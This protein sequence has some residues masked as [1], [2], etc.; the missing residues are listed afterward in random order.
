MRA[1]RCVVGSATGADAHWE[2][3]KSRPFEPA[4]LGKAAAVSSELRIAHALEYIAAQMGEINVKLS[5][6]LAQR[7]G[8]T[9]F[10]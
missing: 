7:S 10:G 8:G 5:G 6:L 1:A 2:H 4:G 9:N 3:E